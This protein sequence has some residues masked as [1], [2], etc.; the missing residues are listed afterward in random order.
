MGS[1]EDSF[2]ICRNPPFINLTVSLSVDVLTFSSLLSQGIFQSPHSA[3]VGAV[4]TGRS[5]SRDLEWT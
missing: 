1:M 3:P 4:R 2:F 5:P